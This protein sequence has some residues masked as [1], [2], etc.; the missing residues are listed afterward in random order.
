MKGEE[1]LE[2]LKQ[3]DFNDTVIFDELKESLLTKKSSQ[4]SEA[5]IPFILVTSGIYNNKV[6]DSGSL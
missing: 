4:R 2:E 1:E 6:D 5:E 3:G